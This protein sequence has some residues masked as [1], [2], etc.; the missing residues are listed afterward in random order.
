MILNM[1]RILNLIF[2]YS[3]PKIFFKNEYV[4]NTLDALKI[5]K[6]IFKITLSFLQLETSRMSENYPY[7]FLEGPET[8]G[9]LLVI[10]SRSW[11]RTTIKAQSLIRVCI[12]IY[13]FVYNNVVWNNKYARFD[14]N[15]CSLKIFF[16]QR[17]EIIQMKTIILV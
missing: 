10:G 1:K 2:K 13:I 11:H 15:C 12:Y 9:F 14:C 8:S 7:C 3:H 16:S 17:T 5:L 6:T 4:K